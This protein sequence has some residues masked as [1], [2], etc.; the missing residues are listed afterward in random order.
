MQRLA[1]VE[2]NDAQD[3]LFGFAWQAY[4]APM[5]DPAIVLYG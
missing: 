1:I 3:A 4:Q 2:C 5:P